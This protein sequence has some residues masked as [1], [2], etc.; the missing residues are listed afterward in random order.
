MDRL[1]ELIS[2]GKVVV[3]VTATLAQS[4]YYISKWKEFPSSW[5]LQMKT[6]NFSPKNVPAWLISCKSECI[7]LINEVKCKIFHRY[8]SFT[9]TLSLFAF[10]CKFRVDRSQTDA[11][12][13]QFTA[14]PDRMMN[15]NINDVFIKWAICLRINSLCFKALLTSWWIFS[16]KWL[17]RSSWL[18][19]CAGCTHAAIGF[20]LFTSN[21]SKTDG[22]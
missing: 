19:T 21:I 18:C 14:C 22:I 20:H 9:V 3:K 7:T 11:T 12:V 5:D 1:S 15:A 10:M 2:V 16:L 8:C 17:H 13:S 6:S 4:A